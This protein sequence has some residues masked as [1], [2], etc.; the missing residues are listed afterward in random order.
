[1]LGWESMDFMHN[2]LYVHYEKLK[3]TFWIGNGGCLIL[4]FGQS[5][6]WKK[7]TANIF[8][9]KIQGA[10]WVIKENT[11]LSTLFCYLLLIMKLTHANW[12]RMGG[13]PFLQWLSI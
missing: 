1:M 6:K 3:L 13:G 4:N 11:A 5:F 12:T 9:L 2:A 8:G 7:L 10:P